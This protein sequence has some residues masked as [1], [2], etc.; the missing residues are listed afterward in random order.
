MPSD[1]ATVSDPYFPIGPEFFANPYRFYDTLRAEDPVHWSDL[2]GG[3]VLSRY[4]DVAAITRHQSITARRMDALIQLL[5]EER[6]AFM[7]ELAEVKAHE[8]NLL[9]PP[10][11]ARLRGLV[12]KAFTPAVVERL[13]PRI[14]ALVDEI[15]DR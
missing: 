11:H 8:M 14:Q 10:E 4:S 2:F 3:W 7:R 1:A 9:D 13:Q 6:R 5:P 15:L 12:S